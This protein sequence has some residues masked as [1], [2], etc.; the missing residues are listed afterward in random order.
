M[1][2][3]GFGLITPLTWVGRLFLIVYAVI[4]MPLA[5]V[6]IS[7]VGKFFCDAGIELFKK[8]TASFTI[9]LLLLLLFYPIIGGVCIH[10]ISQL[11]LFDSF[12]YCTITI[13]TVGFGDIEPP[14]A[15]PYLILFIFIGVILVTISVDVVATNII[16]HIHYMGRQMGKATQIAD[17]MI[18][19]AQSININRG[20]RLGISQLDAFAKMGAMIRLAPNDGTV[21]THEHVEENGVQ[22][23]NIAFD[24][25]ADIDLIDLFSGSNHHIEEHHLCGNGTHHV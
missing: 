23:K 1:V 20:L 12:Y 6:T 5:L 14:I 2:P 4:G 9:V 15:V 18:M 25:K 21:V 19:M 7:D 16:H 3:V 10:Y 8:S 22:R 13:L 24:P 11:S 17:K